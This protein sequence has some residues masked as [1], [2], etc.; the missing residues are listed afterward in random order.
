MVHFAFFLRHHTSVLHP[1]S[2]HVQMHRGA[3]KAGNNARDDDGSRRRDNTGKTCCGFV[4]IMEQ[5]RELR[6]T[7]NKPRPWIERKFIIGLVLA[8]VG[9]AWYVYIGRLC[10]PMVRQD[11]GALGNRVMGIFFLVVYCLLGLMFFWTYI[12]LILTPPGFA[13]DYPDYWEKQ[14]PFGT[15]TQGGI[16]GERYELIPPSTLGD[17]SSNGIAERHLPVYSKDT[18]HYVTHATAVKPSVNADPKLSPLPP[19]PAHLP[20]QQARH[21]QN[22]QTT[23]S[24]SILARLPP[25]EPVLLKEYRVCKRE[26][27][28][29]PMRAHHCRICG[30]CVLMMDHHCPWVGQCVGA[31]NYKFF[32]IFL[33]WSSL[34]TL[35]ILGTL[36][37]LVAKNTSHPSFSID[38]QHIVLIALSG[39]FSL[40]TVMMLAAHVFMTLS[41]VT[42]IESLR[43]QDMRVDEKEI[44]AELVPTCSTM[45]VFKKRRQI[46]K[47]WDREWGRPRSEMNIWWLGSKKANWEQ[48]MGK[49][50]LGWILPIGTSLGDGLTYPTNPRFDKDGRFRRRSEWPVELQ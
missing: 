45:N 47:E 35:W 4:E 43:I 10:V 38:S 44:L 14:Q 50:K 8:I 40:F 6:F 25:K 15:S 13:R 1:P 26:Q 17:S 5:R 23:N 21:P 29:K 11:V 7:S 34:Y 32:V 31:F 28:I 46:M 33:F 9:Y 16:G 22:G 41:N 19:K 48:R 36:V 18:S 37:G 30:T 24:A 27:H 3:R 42:S 39:I 12:K 49:S 20:M 2:F